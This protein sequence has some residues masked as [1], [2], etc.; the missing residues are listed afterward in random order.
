MDEQQEA[1]E[2]WVR[3]LE[4]LEAE[5]VGVLVSTGSTTGVSTG[6]T[7]EAGLTD[8]KAEWAAPG[9]IG[10]I[11]AELQA[12]AREILGGQR[13]LIAE[14]ERTKHATAAQLAALRR[15]PATRP[16]G[17]SVYLDVSS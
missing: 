14:L 17:A 9:D 12:R 8:G 1:R 6:S 16:S 4:E 2:A 15:M 5:L 7:T 10:P 11:P 13:E 3:V